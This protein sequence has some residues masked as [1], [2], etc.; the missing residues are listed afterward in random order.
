[1]GQKPPGTISQLAEAALQGRLPHG[2]IDIHRL[3]RRC[4]ASLVKESGTGNAELGILVIDRL[5][6]QGLGT[7]LLRRLIE[8]A[9]AENYAGISAAMLAQN[10]AM[11][12]LAVRFGF[13]IAPGAD[14]GTLNAV[15]PLQT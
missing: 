12:A 7:E 11:R 5:Q 10:T 4:G 15:L 6:R 14:S 8:I 13:R 3:A 2:R 1:L 9:R